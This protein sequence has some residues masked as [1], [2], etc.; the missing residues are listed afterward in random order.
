MIL[1]ILT[2]TTA[3]CAITNGKNKVESKG[4]SAQI[5]AQASSQIQA[6]TQAP[7]KK[8]LIQAVVKRGSD[9]FSYDDPLKLK[10]LGIRSDIQDLLWVAP[11]GGAGIKPEVKQVEAKE[12]DR[13]LKNGDKMKDAFCLVR[14]IYEPYRPGQGMNDLAHKDLIIYT[15]PGN[16]NDAYLGVQNPDNQTKWDLYR[17][18]DYGQ[19]LKK[20]VDLFLRIS[21]GL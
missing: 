10:G 1:F 11:R 6:Q 14:L 16:V 7:T 19:W 5:T 4:D 13:V 2:I 8:K 3:A 18:P 21:K 20:E 9:V 15:D 17:L 12:L